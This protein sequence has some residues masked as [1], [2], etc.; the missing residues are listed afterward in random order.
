MFANEK[1]IT[2]Q[3]EMMSAITLAGISLFYAIYILKLDKL[4]N[5]NDRKE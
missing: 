5:N 2:V 1:A 3:N 4:Q